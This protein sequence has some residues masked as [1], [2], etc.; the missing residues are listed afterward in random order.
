M[1][2]LEDLNA[3]KLAREFRKNISLM[4]KK[5]PAEEKFKLTD[6][7][8][9]SSRSVSANIA[10]GSDRFY[11]QENIAFCRKS[12]GSLVET[13]DHLYCAF[14]EKYINETELNQ[15][16]EELNIL[17]KVLNGYISYLKKSKSGEV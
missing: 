6:Q 10:E 7:M 15:A 16:K 14:D 4:T 11:F 3:W 1:K 5:F 9:R 12:R 8:I 13:L 17:L 2:L